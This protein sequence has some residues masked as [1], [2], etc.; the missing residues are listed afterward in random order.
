MRRALLLSLVLSLA[1]A[2]ACDQMQTAGTAA[3]DESRTAAAKDLSPEELGQI[4][5]ELRKSPDRAE[6]I[7]SERGLDQ[8]TFETA[9]RKIS[10]DPEASKRYAEAY[11][12][13]NG[14]AS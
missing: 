9:I 3:G 5:A 12:Q 4:G 7:L 1:L 14:D 8:Q 6:Q 11:K 10:E 2:G 13:A